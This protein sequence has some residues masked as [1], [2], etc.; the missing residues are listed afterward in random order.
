MTLIYPSQC[1][2][3]HWNGAL[4][5]RLTRAPLEQ[6]LVTQHLKLAAGSHRDSD[7]IARATVLIIECGLKEYFHS[8]EEGLA[9][10]QHAAIG[11]LACVVSRAA[12]ALIQ[13]PDAWRIPALLSAARLL[14][15]WIGLNPAACASASSIH[16]FTLDTT[17]QAGRQVD[18]DIADGVSRAMRINDSPSL[19]AIALNIAAILSTPSQNST[20]V[21]DAVLPRA[22]ARH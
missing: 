17:S 19:R 18:I 11:R 21:S 1:K 15:P 4:Q 5:A 13:E 8:R 3:H 22:I 6:F 16:E 20:P 10:P 2:T 9:E 12:A 14:T 7:N